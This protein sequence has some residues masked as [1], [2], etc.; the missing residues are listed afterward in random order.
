MRSGLSDSVLTA[1]VLPLNIS[2]YN[3][4]KNEAQ[5]LGKQK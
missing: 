5:T 1:V 2:Q 3:C 4:A